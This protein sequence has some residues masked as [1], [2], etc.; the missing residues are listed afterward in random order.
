MW[1]WLLCWFVDL[2]WS[3]IV[4]CLFGLLRG[5]CFVNCVFILFL[6]VWGFGFMCFDVLLFLV[7]LCF[8]TNLCCFHGFV[9]EFLVVWLCICFV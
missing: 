9:K 2:L 5:L 1:C 6:F 4:F 8:I 7:V 3:V